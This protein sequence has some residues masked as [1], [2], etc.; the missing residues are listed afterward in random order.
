MSSAGQ[1]TLRVL[2]LYFRY[3]PE[4]GGMEQHIERLSDAQRQ[5]GVE[6]VN[7]FNRGQSSASS[8]IQLLPGADLEVLRPQALRN[9]AF[10]AAAAANSKVRRW[11][12]SGSGP[13]VVHAHGAWS[14]FLFARWLAAFLGANATVGTIHGTTDK[15]HMRLVHNLALRQLGAIFATGRREYSAAKSVVRERVIHLPSA[16]SD[17]FCRPFDRPTVRE[18]DIVCVGKLV[19]VKRMN[20]VLE[21]ARRLPMRTFAIIGDGPEWT[22][23]QRQRAELM[24]QNVTF[25]GRLAPEQVRN[26]LLGARLFLSTSVEEGTPTSVLEAMA[27]GLPVVVTPS[28]DYDWIIEPGINGTITSGWSVDEIVASIDQALNNDA[29][30]L[31]S[32]VES[33]RVKLQSITWDANAAKVTQIMQHCAQAPSLEAPL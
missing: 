7:V 31:P 5:L 14:D 15:Q 9:A 6:V 17:L 25:F 22:A 16:P 3:P 33:N 28:N 32:V 30:W 18:F 2:R 10:Y 27:V 24:L 4:P 13:L 23:L 1:K 26:V 19:P 20:L 8:A 11:A 29:L 12:K 21:A